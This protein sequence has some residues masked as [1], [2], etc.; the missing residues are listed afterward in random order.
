MPHYDMPIFSGNAPQFCRIADGQI[1]E[2]PR[3][4]PNGSDLEALV[5][6]GDLAA[7]RARG[8]VPHYL[9]DPGGECLT[10]S[11]FEV[12]ADEVAEIK[13][14]RAYTAEELAAQSEQAAQP[15]PGQAGPG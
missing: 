3:Q 14:Y 12:L 7:L 9:Y 15:G 4:F 6:A 10:H 2:G 1:T 13:H 8:W 11:T 5:H